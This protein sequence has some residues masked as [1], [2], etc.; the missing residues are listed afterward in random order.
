MITFEALWIPEELR[1][2]LEIAENKDYVYII[3]KWEVLLKWH[4]E[5]GK[6]WAI[7]QDYIKEIYTQIQEI[8]NIL[9][10]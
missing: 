7:H 1:E 8:N 4:K 9:N 10:K 6:V 3:Y 2:K 5:N